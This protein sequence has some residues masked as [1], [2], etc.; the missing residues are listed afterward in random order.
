MDDR[1][2]LEVLGLLQADAR[3]TPDQIGAM[4]D[5]SPEAVAETVAELQEQRVIVRY[6]TVI[7]WERVGVESV[8]ALIDVKV[9]PQRDVGFDR[10]AE[11]IARFSEVKSCY[12]MSGAYDLQVVVEARGLKEISR[13]VFER[14]ST[15]D[16]VA[17][18]A[19]HFVMKRYKH[20]GV[21]FG[22]GAPDDRL[23]VT[24]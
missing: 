13:F 19:T 11:R 24:P 12:L 6:G 10:L 18:T 23:A 20:E 16:G 15:L 8:T 2:R 14:L 17:S 5:E 9:T 1:K 3:L 4:V 22:G 21:S 7:D